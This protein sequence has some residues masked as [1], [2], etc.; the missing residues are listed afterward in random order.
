MLLAG[1]DCPDIKVCILN[2]ST[3]SITKYLQSIGRGARIAPNKKEFFILD[4]GNNI[5]RHGLYEQD[6][7]WSL[8][9]DEGSNGGLQPSKL[10]DPDK[11]D[12]NGKER[13]WE[14]SSYVL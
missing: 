12:I 6:R 14:I 7:N 8:W 5:D 10:C 13:L 1:F 4:F 9:H 11:G 2:Y 3:L